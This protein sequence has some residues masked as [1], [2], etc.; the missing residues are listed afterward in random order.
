MSLFAEYKKERENAIVVEDKNG[1]AV[2]KVEGEY[3]YIVDI[4]VIPKLR[5]SDI[6]SKYADRIAEIAKKKGI[7]KLLGSVDPRANGSTTSLKV[8]LGYG[9]KLLCVEGPMIYFEKEI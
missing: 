7:K 3:M 8:V 2:A 1:F 6:A 9:F 4:Y 5:Q